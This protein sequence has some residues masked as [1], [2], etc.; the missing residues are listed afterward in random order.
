[1]VA[2]SPIAY[3]A[4]LVAAGPAVWLRRRWGDKAIAAVLLLGTAVALG[5]AVLMRPYLRGELFSIILTPSLGAA[6]GCA[7][8]IPDSLMTAP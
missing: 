6:L 1:M 2:G 4:A 8:E 3:G 5:T 7:S